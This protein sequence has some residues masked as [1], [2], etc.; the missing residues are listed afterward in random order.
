MTKVFDVYKPLRNKI[1]TCNLQLCL[2][3]IWAYSQHLLGDRI[4]PDI[5][6][7][8]KRLQLKDHVYPWNL[9]VLARELV[10]HAS[11]RG[12]VRINTWPSLASVVNTLREVENRIAELHDDPD[13]A[14]AILHSIAH[15][16]FPWQRRRDRQSLM[17][18][19]KIF[20]EANVERVLVE[21]TGLTMR[22][23]YFMG[24]AVAGHL[25]KSPG[26]NSMQDY[27]QFGISE[28]QADTFFKKLSVDVETLRDKTEAA[29]KYDGSWE[30]TWNPLEATPLV[31]LEPLYPNR[32]H[33]PIPE[34]LL[35]RI[36]QGVFYDLVATVDFDNAYGKAYQRYV[37]EVIKA[38]FQKQH[39]CLLAEQEFMA[40]KNIKH[41]FDWILSDGSGTIFFECKTKRLK[42][43]AKIADAKAL[44]G[45]EIS[46][47][48]GAVVQSYKNLLDA[49][50]GLTQ[51]KPD[52]RPAHVAVVTLED[53]YLVGPLV[54]QLLD[55]HV[56]KG[57]TA[58]GIDEGII[59]QYPYT[60]ASIAEFERVSSVIATVGIASFFEKKYHPQYA[61]WMIETIAKTCFASEWW[62]PRT[63]LFRD[64][65]DRL[66]PEMAEA[67]DDEFAK[68][69][70]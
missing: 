65:W 14:L 18:Y 16:Q 4:L 31:R 69:V 43:A 21:N 28:A 52:G 61:N 64:E 32:L 67:W 44:L 46:I 33:C 45:E 34:L 57:I 56:A 9:S 25:I 19:L 27:S 10:L 63:L 13:N 42:Q 51:W 15:Q 26:I 66:I 55:A 24:L 2:E 60:I 30:Y 37:G 40:G 7:G 62:K 12:T 22:Q 11:R 3:D 17:R 59:K 6:A 36:S 5:I 20:G 58:A 50:A 54:F 39:H 23:L 38:T 8:G 47:L 48:A 49:L 68:K 53:W 41:G 70:K 1:R 29:Q 35:R